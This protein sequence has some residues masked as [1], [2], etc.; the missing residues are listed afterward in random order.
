MELGL[1]SAVWVVGLP[2]YGDFE[3]Y[4]PSCSMAD[5]T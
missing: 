1:W 5:C 4:W 3:D 2:D